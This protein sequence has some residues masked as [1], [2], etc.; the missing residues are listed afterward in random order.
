MLSV[1]YSECHKLALYAECLYAE[2]CSAECSSA[3]QIV[4]GKLM[5]LKKIAIFEIKINGFKS[6]IL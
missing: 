1:V 6:K 5:V 3:F 2:C 4:E